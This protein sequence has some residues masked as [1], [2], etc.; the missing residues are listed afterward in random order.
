MI[1]LIKKML[2]AH[3]KTPLKEMV[4]YSSCEKPKKRK[5]KSSKLKWKHKRKVL[6][7]HKSF[8]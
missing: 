1:F 8:K 3:T 6:K 5:E 4:T 2:R 7:R